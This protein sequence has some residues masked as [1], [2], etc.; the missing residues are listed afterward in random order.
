L[1]DHCHI[2]NSNRKIEKS[3]DIGRKS[4]MDIRV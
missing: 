3:S 2:I 1:L 4:D